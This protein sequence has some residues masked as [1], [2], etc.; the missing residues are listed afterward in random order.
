VSLGPD[1][2]M[3]LYRYISINDLQN[4]LTLVQ[5]CGAGPLIGR[6]RLRPINP[7]PAPA[8]FKMYRLRLRSSQSGDA[9]F[10]CIFPH[11]TV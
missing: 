3:L 7:D 1:R 6:L 8:P 4:T 10:M 9:Y 5:C 11:R 2:S